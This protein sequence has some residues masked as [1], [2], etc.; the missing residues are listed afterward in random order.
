MK[1]E[2]SEIIISEKFSSLC[3]SDYETGKED[4]STPKIRQRM[5]VTSDLITRLMTRLA[6]RRPDEILP[7]NCRFNQPMN[8]GG[9]VV[10]IEDPPCSRTIQLDMDLEHNIEKLRKTGKLKH[11]GYTQKLLKMYRGPKPFRLILGFPYVVYIMNITMHH[12]LC[13]LRIFYRLHPITSPSDYLF[14]PNLLNIDGSYNVCLGEGSA[15]GNSISETCIGALNRF[16]NNSFNADY[17]QAY[18]NYQDVAE[19]S[20]FLTW[21][22]YTHRDP[23]FVFNVKWKAHKRNLKEEIN[24]IAGSRRM[25]PKSYTF[26]NLTELFT[27]PV[28][29]DDRQVYLD[30]CEHIILGN[31]VL[32]L[33]DKID[34]DNKEYWVS[35]FKG[36]IGYPPQAI[37]LIDDNEELTEKLLTEKF[38]ASLAKTLI[39]VNSIESLELKNGVTIKPGDVVEL[40][41]PFKSYRK[42]NEIRIALDESTEVKLGTDYY[43]ANA[44]DLQIFDQKVKLYGIE[45]EIGSEYTLVRRESD[46]LI[47]VGRPAKLMGIDVT[48]EGMLR[49]HFRDDDSGYEVRES[50]ETLET[51]YKLMEEDTSVHYPVFRIGPKIFTSSNGHH[52]IMKGNG[53]MYD[54]VSAEAALR[55]SYD[56]DLALEHLLTNGEFNLPSYDIDLNFKVGDKV[57]FVDWNIPEDMTVIRE[58]IGIS[59][60][61]NDVIRI[62][63]QSSEG[64]IKTMDY[65][66]LSRARV[67]PGKIRKIVEEYNGLKAGT[68]LKANVAGI[69]KFPKKDVNQIIGFITDT[70]TGVPLMLCSNRCTIWAHEDYLS[71]FS[72]LSPS[73]RLWSRVQVAPP[74]LR[75]AMQMGDLSLY[76]YSSRWAPYM[77]FK[78]PHGRI[79]KYPTTHMSRYITSGTIYPDDKV[80]RWGLLTPRFTQRQLDRFQVKWVYPNM[81]GGYIEVPDRKGL[82]MQADWRCACSTSS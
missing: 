30:P 51:N 33:G 42:V 62:T 37:V 35:G 49:V 77:L 47:Y 54:G 13:G 79:R 68:K 11:Y 67:Y 5:L 50:Y 56:R 40:R 27:E 64:D 26:Y 75:I 21:Q 59:R 44:L 78:D 45:L 73:S 70:G 6:N 66:D 63:A 7:Q 1:R 25:Q 48:N 9:R 55:F 81:H 74:A 57:V 41:Q 16:W 46:V 12:E 29:T 80:L 20:D 18:K 17:I 34:I 14:L 31:E 69:S 23:M 4:E 36:M 39:K 19:V 24:R 52:R 32:S 65:A 8:S 76:S 38:I 43:F 60:D 72:F 28:R 22:Y 15:H 10:V 53:M 58:I 2:R 71:K 3:S 61:E 82:R